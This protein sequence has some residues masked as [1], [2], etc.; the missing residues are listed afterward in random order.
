MAERIG[1]YIC[2]CG[3]NLKAALDIEKLVAFSQ[4]LENVAVAK[5]FNLI[6]SAEGQESL[7]KDIQENHLT[8]VVIAACSPKEHELTFR[9]ILKR[10]GINPFLLQVANIREQCAWVIKDRALATNKAKRMIKAAVKRVLRHEPLEA[11][12]IECQIDAV[13]VGAG[14]A[15]INA[16]LTL[17]DKKRK[18]YLIERLPVIGGRVNRYEK[19]FPSLECA[20]CMLEPQ[21]D[22]VLHHERI[23]VFTYS[24]IQEVK[25]FYGNFMLKVKRYARYVNPL[26]CIG[27]GACFAVCPVKVKNEYEAGLNERKAIYIPYAGS[28]PNVAVIDREHCLHFKKQGC[29]LCQKACA[30]GAIN[31]EEA[32]REQELKAGAVVLA[33]G[34]D[35]FDPHR[36]PEYGYGKIEDVYTSLEFERLLDASG[37][38][39]GKIRLKNG[40]APKRIALIHC[41]G[42]R[43]SK[44]NEYCSGICCMYLLKFSR[45]IK[46]KLPKAYIAELYSDFCLPT[47][48]AQAFLDNL[49][50]KKAADFIHLQNFDSLKISKNKARILIEFRDISRKPKRLAVDLVVLAP[51]VEPAKGASEVAKLFDISR[52]KYGFFSEEHAQIA[53]VSTALEGIFIAG[54]NQGPKDIPHSVAQAQAAAGKILSRL[55]FG[56]KLVPE[57]M[58]AF[59]QE[60]F[61]SGCKV[62]VSLCPYKAITY[63]AKKKQARINELLCRGC[64]ICVAACPAGAISARHFTD[65]QISA[66]IEGLLK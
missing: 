36:A 41:V 6:C 8:R 51:A 19:V 65:K 55:H 21:L 63:D 27:C 23:E 38:T 1:V 29:D 32:D 30:S 62:C 33:T 22:E 43:T 66:E 10:A 45:L 61:C 12:E 48:E 39:K 4:K 64:G 42:S 18:V 7:K 5:S 24:G 53:P 3:P 57:A 9:N 35:V 25:G 31:Y 60:D 13:V 34:F 26:T 58:T 47:K 54:C 50:A 15:G 17:A 59:V 44:Y 20:S 56:D 2:E 40:R 16:A 28:L 37:P 14:V 46:E 11:K 49:A 52:D